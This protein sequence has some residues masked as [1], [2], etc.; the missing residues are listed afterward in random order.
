L[1]PISAKGAVHAVEE[2]LA[3]FGGLDDD[4]ALLALG[5]PEAR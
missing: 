1:A 2:L 5:V 3:G 4:V